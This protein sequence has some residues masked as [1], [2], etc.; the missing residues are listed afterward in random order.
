M[1]ERLVEVGVQFVQFFFLEFGRVHLV[2]YLLIFASLDHFHHILAHILHLVD[3][4][5]AQLH[6][7]ADI[8][9]LHTV[10]VRELL[11]EDL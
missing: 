4:L 5:R 1:E 2:E 3:V 8:L 10:G 9:V 7:P 6:K 11:I